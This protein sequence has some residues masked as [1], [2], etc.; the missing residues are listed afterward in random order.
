MRRDVI[1]TRQARVALEDQPE[2]LPREA[3]PT[4]AQEQ[5]RISTFARDSTTPAAQIL[6]QRFHGRRLQRDQPLAATFAKA[7]YPLVRQL[8]TIE[9]ERHQLTHAYTS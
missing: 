9:I 1:D 3:L 7:P 8:H 6:A 4:M 5:R 2:A